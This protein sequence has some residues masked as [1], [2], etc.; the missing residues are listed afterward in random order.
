MAIAKTNDK[1]GIV[2]VRMIN[3]K[4]TGTVTLRDY[5]DSNTGEVREFLDAHGNPRVKKY[6]KALT[7]L[8]LNVE[9]DRLEYE[10]LKHHP[11]YVN[12]SEAILKIVDVTE[13]AE[14]RTNAREAALDALIQAKGLRGDKLYNFARVLGIQTLNQ[15][16]TI[17][18]DKVYDIAEKTPTEFLQAFNDPNRT[19]K[20]TLHKGKLKGVFAVKNNI[21]KFRDVL[22]GANIDEAILWL[23]DNDDLMPSI[24]KELSS[25]KN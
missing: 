10:H 18:K 22:M 17:V 7:V 9:N 24:R 15:L 8:R 12:G 4:R 11:L 1:G 5:Y 14:T 23:K 6:T 16:E 25:V 2:E 3:P 21:W 19:Y 20:E 13:E